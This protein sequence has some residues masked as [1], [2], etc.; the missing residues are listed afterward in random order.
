MKSRILLFLGI[1]ELVVALGALPAG[2]LFITHPD[3]SA[4]QVSVDML[5]GSPFP[6][7]LIPGLFLFTVNGVF[8]LF[9]SLLSFTRRKYAGIAGLALGTILVLWI[10]IQVAIIGLNSFLQYAFFLIGV[11]EIWLAVVILKQR[12]S[13]GH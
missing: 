10:C 12:T 9:A 1:T 2:W 11:L 4:M 3:G 5:K 7:F 13:S 8:Q 6:N